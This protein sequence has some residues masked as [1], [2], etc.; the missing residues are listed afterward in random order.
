MRGSWTSDFESYK[1]IYLSSHNLKNQSFD[2]FLRPRVD[3]I[4]PSE[5]INFE[6]NL[7]K[8]ETY[9][10]PRVPSN[11]RHSIIDN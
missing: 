4:Q 6:S 3:L 2:W 10:L 11:D 9:K 7:L 1:K 8:F 5:E